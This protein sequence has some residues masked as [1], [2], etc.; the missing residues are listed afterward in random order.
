MKKTPC[1]ARG[2]DYSATYNR[3]RVTWL[4]EAARSPKL[5]ASAVRVG[6]LFATFFNADTRETVNPS[7]EW[8]M[9]NAHMSR[10]TLAK[11]L[12]ELEAAGFI[13]IHRLH[14]YRSQ[15]EMPFNGDEPWK[16]LSSKTEL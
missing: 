5:S 7:Y 3:N 8:L 16:P 4:Y 11:A 6:L 13:Q 14:R 15:Y 10:A 2:M 9:E 1:Y 12:K